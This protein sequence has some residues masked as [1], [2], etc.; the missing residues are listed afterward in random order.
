MSGINVLSNDSDVDG[1][2]LYLLTHDTTTALGGTVIRHIDD[3]L[4]YYPAANFNG[5]DSFSYTV[6]DGK[7][8]QATGNVLITVV[9]V[10][11]APTLL[12]SASAL[13]VVAGASVSIDVTI[14]DVD[15]LDG[16]T[17]TARSVDGLGVVTVS[18]NRVTYAATTAGSDTVQITVTDAGGLSTTRTAGVTVAAAPVAASSGGGGGGGS[19]S[20]LLLMLGGLPL[21]RRRRA[22]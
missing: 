5:S 20:W 3:T 2:V 4:S 15:G 10:N 8:G 21:V 19:I 18:G 16:A 7:G 1:D 13:E 6:T 11:D 22:A 12:L 9:P 17:I 14:S